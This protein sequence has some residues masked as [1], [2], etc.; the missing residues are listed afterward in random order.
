MYVLTTSA[1]YK[2]VS[3]AIEIIFDQTILS[4]NIYGVML[5]SKS[6]DYSISGTKLSISSAI[7]NNLSI[8][9]HLV[10]IAT[11]LGQASIDITIHNESA[12]VPY[13]VRADIDSNPGYTYIYWNSDFDATK[14][15]VQIG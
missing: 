15:V 12:Y 11:N 3:T 6:V 9:K 13:N 2:G 14:Y 10:E 1:Y 4:S 7:A 8:G 5:D